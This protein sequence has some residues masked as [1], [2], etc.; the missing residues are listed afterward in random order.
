MPCRFLPG[1]LWLRSLSG[2]V[3]GLP[4][5]TGAHASHQ[6]VRHVRRWPLK[7]PRRLASEKAACHLIAAL[8]IS[9]P[10]LLYG[11]MTC[12]QYIR[13][14]CPHPQRLLTSA[15]GALSLPCHCSRITNTLCRLHS[16]TLKLSIEIS[17]TPEP[18]LFPVVGE[19]NGSTRFGAIS[20][21]GQGVCTRVASYP[22]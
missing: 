4:P 3:A 1:L 19:I 18:G 9:I 15:D 21:I 11:G 5:V 7:A 22:V 14:P 16:P 6:P 13:L 10:S 12:I 8:L 17:N 2:L 20:P